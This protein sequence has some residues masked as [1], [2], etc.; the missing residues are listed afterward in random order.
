MICVWIVVGSG[1]E[2]VGF[3]NGAHA[4]PFKFVVSHA[5]F[6]SRSKGLYR[7]PRQTDDAEVLRCDD[8]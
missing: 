4:E 2:G 6:S 7:Q 3:F 8:M 5:I 1:E